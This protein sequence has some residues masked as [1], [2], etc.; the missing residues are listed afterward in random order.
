M[1]IQ[2][3]EEVLFRADLKEKIDFFSLTKDRKLQTYEKNRAKTTTTN[4]Q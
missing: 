1:K 2:S 3:W 4:Q